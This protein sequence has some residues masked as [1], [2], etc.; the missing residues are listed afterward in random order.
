VT[1]IGISRPTG[2]RASGATRGTGKAKSSWFC[3]IIDTSSSYASCFS[4]N[5]T[6]STMS[7]FNVS[8]LSRRTAIVAGLAFAL[9]GCATPSGPV[10]LADSIA[11]N[12]AL[13]T[14]NGLVV[15]AGLADTLKTGGPFTVFAPTNEAFKAVSAAA[16]ADLEKHPEKLKAVL[17]YHVVPG[18]TMAADVK[19]SSVKTV[20]GA[21]VALAKAGDFVTIESGAV[22]TAN[23]VA[24]NGVIHTID[25]VL[26][27]PVKK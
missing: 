18:K 25:T 9:A 1:K 10:N 17:T 2:N 4:T 16:M 12:P 8:T 20:N 24:T 19:N 26:M 27:P 21:D 13:S 7:Q 23:V 14:L 22:V 11:A 6:E 5:Q 15:K 3:H